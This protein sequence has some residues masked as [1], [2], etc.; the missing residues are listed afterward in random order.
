MKLVYKI[1]IVCGVAELIHQL[2]YWR[3]YNYFNNLRI[4]SKVSKQEYLKV[5][6]MLMKLNPNL[7]A[8]CK[9]YAHTSHI[10]NED[11]LYN[12][13]TPH[14]KERPVNSL[15]V[16]CSRLYWRYSPFILELCMKTI[17]QIGNMYVR[18]GLGYSRTWHNT[19]DGYYSV[20]THIVPGT[21]PILFFP[22]LGLGA[23]IYAKFAKSLGRT[24][25]I[26]EVPNIGYSTPLSN[27]Q[28]THETIYEVVS[29]HVDDGTDIFAHSLGSVHAAMYL[30][31]ICNKPVPNHNAVICDG[32]VNPC[33]LLT[34]HIYSFVGLTEY[35]IIKKKPKRWL[36]FAIFVYMGAS[37]LEFQSWAKRFHTAYD[38]TLWKTYPNTKIH[39]VYSKY[40]ILYDTEYIANISN[41]LLLPKG[42]HGYSIFGKWD[43]SIY[44]EML[45]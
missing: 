32:F 24:V 36:E 5:V 6:D 13:L 9:Q 29:K 4:M 20:W 39:Y 11:D 7:F 41:C 12:A 27:S 33:D 42:G 2:M 17:R 22:G 23:V 30:N 1:G 14:Y 28:A 35:S 21:K 45:Q 38:G 10:K 19:H 44:Q 40:D 3:R 8:R 16:G 15:Q 34:S 25:H 18:Y 43:K 26:L 37:T 31:R